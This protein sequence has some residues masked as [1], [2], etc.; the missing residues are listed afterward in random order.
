MVAMQSQQAWIIL[1]HSASPEVQVTQQPSFVISTL[2]MPIV[3][4][5]VMTHI[6][7]II[8]QQEQR[9]PASIVQRF[10]IMAQA[11]ASSHLQVIFIPPWHFSIWKV[12][13]G[14]IIMFGAVE[15]PIVVGAMPGMPAIMFR[16]IISVV[17]IVSL[18]RRPPGQQVGRTGR[19]GQNHG[20]R[21][22]SE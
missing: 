6:P 2:H 21:T 4:V 15:A 18:L 14:T 13:R 12:Q 8:R 5:Q 3:R 17:L 22:R 7:F 11:V 20:K 1:Q 9:P 16:S 10:C 19:S